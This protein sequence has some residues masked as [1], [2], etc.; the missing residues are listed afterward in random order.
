LATLIISVV[1]IAL[2]FHQWYFPYLFNLGTT[3]QH[4]E[5]GYDETIHFSPTIGGHIV[6][7]DVQHN[8]LQLF[9]LTVVR[10]A[11]MT[12]R[13]SSRGQTGRR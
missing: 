4:L 2:Q 1:W 10:T 11:A 3:D 7:P 9:S 8:M 12:Y 13:Q 5:H 6:T